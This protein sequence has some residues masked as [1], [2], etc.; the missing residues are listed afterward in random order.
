MELV[1]G[2]V[3]VRIT[4][5]MFLTVLVGPTV[6]KD[7]ILTEG[8]GPMD[9][10]LG[11]NQFTTIHLEGLDAAQQAGMFQSPPK[12]V[13]SDNTIVQITPT[14]DGL[15]CRIE[16][17]TPVQLGS[18]TVTVTDADD[19]TVPPLVFNVTIGAESITHLGATIDP[20]TEKGATPTPTPAPTPTPTP[21]PTPTPTPGPTPNPNPNPAPI[22]PTP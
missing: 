1:I 17:A 8:S 2:S 10:N 14:D 3:R 7:V 22:P 16:G 19:S 9:I 11:D 4:R 6:V 12:W 18:A 5:P 21:G 13:S 15:S 20:P